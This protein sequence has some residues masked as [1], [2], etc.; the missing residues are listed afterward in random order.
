MRTL[1]SVEREKRNPTP[2]SM[3]TLQGQ[4]TCFQSHQGLLVQATLVFASFGSQQKVRGYK[5]TGGSRGT[6]LEKWTLVG[7]VLYYATSD[8]PFNEAVCPSLSATTSRAGNQP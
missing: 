1:G 6:T 8:Q 4:I 7:T 3:V 5:L 2:Q